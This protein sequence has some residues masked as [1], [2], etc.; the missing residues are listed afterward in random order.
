MLES[1]ARLDELPRKRLANASRIAFRSSS[2]ILPF[3]FLSYFFMKSLCPLEPP[4]LAHGGPEGRV[5]ELRAWCSGFLAAVLGASFFFESEASL[6]DL[7]DEL[8]RKRL[9]YAA[10][11]AFRS[12]SSIFP[13]LFLSN[14]LKNSLRLL[15]RCA[16]AGAVPRHI[17]PARIRIIVVVFIESS[18]SCPQKMSWYR[19]S[20]TFITN[21]R[22]PLP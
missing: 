11:I 9:S 12:S 7:L 3:L 13:S 8:P 20:H 10:R 22:D 21:R 15:G 14:F 4:R 17:V 5:D 6:G 18:L 1:E 19:T 2:S 16:S